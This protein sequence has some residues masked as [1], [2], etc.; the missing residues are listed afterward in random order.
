[1]VTHNSGRH[2][3]W[4]GFEV[5]ERRS[6]GSEEEVDHQIQRPQH[7]R[8][9]PAGAAQK[10]ILSSEGLHARGIWEKRANVNAIRM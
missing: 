4:H 10:H 6:V 9:Q 5:L 3:G 7:H 2:V 1:M 8:A